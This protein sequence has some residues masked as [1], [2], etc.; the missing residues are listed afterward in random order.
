MR[1]SMRCDGCGQFVSERD[2]YYGTAV[3]ENNKILCQDCMPAE[4]IE[5]LD[6]SDI[7]EG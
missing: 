6:K 2:L 5:D 7:I 3:K 1:H 4:N